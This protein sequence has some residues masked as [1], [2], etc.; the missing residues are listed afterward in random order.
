M[1]VL[2]TGAY[3]FIGSAV[4]AELVACGHEV[5]GMGRSVARA[6]RQRPDL[7]WIALDIGTARTPEDW[8]P[9]LKDIDAVVNCAGL[10]QDSPAD[11]VAA[12]QRDAMRALFAACETHGI[13]RFI[14]ISAI[15]VEADTAFARTK[16]EADAALMA[17]KL[18]WVVLRPSIVVGRNVYGGTALLRAL[19]VLPLLPVGSRD[20]L[21]QPVQVTDLAEAVAYFLRPDAPVKNL[22]EVAGPERM[23]LSALVASYRRWL[24]H[25]PARIVRIPDWLQAGLFRL[26]DAVSWLGWRPPVRTTALRQLARDVVGDHKGWTSVT[27]IT[28][29]RLGDQLAREPASVQERWFGAL[30]LLKPVLLTG[31]VLFWIATGLITLG[32]ARAAGVQLLEQAGLGSLSLAAALAGAAADLAIGIGIAIRRTARLALLG[33]IGLSFAYLVLGGFLLPALWSDPLGPLVKIVPVL[34]AS[35]AALAIL[36]D[37]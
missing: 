33:S 10:L 4:V 9:Y 21:L 15:G 24:G 35:F 34:L 3:G 26:G 32:P 18:D 31:L 30:F 27:G 23:K 28:A 37:R 5:T 16:R 2:V 20:A 6:L 14:Q 11:D 29:T 25:A 1:R 19:A 22:L 17:S 7:R 8:A 36:D 12:V 13:R